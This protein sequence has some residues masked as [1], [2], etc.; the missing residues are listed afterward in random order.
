MPYFDAI[1]PS[2]VINY[3][4]SFIVEAISCPDV[5]STESL[6]VTPSKKEF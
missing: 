1:P 2:P 6:L 4:E 3:N 5:T